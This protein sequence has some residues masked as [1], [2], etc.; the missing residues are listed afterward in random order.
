MSETSDVF[1]TQFKISV[2]AR[3]TLLTL[4]LRFKIGWYY[5]ASTATRCGLEGPGIE[6]RSWQRLADPS[7]PT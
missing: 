5:V 6:F 2:W 7:R 4:V 1:I 3:L